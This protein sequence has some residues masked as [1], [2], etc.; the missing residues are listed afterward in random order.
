MRQKAFLR[1]AAAAAL[2]AGLEGCPAPV[3][4]RLLAEHEGLRALL[5]ASPS[6]SSPEVRAG[7][8][9]PA[10]LCSTGACSASIVAAAAGLG[11]ACGDGP[12]RQTAAGHLGG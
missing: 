4:A 1:E 2:L 9:T 11:K 10:R 8:F 6:E 12:W 7:I 5:M 3:L